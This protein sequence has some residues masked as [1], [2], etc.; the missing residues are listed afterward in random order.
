MYTVA[1][2][3]EVPADAPAFEREA[4]GTF[5]VW[6]W[7]DPVP[8]AK[9]KKP[10]AQEVRRASNRR[11]TPGQFLDRFTT[12]EQRALVIEAR[13]DTLLGLFLLRL[14]TDGEV[15]LD[16]NATA[17]AVARMVGKGVITPERVDQ[18]LA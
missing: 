14:S 3:A 17:T 1:T 7:T 12:P 13:T 9:L 8:G 18:V 11:P 15:R 5:T 16:S 4:D 10:T 6:E 2:R